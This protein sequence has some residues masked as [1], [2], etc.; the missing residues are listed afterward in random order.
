MSE[1][2]ARQ[3][4][5]FKDGPIFEGSVFQIISLHN[6]SMN[7]SICVPHFAFRI[8]FD[9]GVLRIELKFLL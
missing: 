3:Q 2:V 4:T 9:I 1:S 8:N 5:F 7:I 6:K